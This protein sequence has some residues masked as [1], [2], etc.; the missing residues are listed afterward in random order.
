MEQRERELSE[1]A[2][3]NRAAWDAESDAYQAR[4]GEQLSD[5]RRGWGVWNIP[6]AEL[7]VLGEVAGQ[8]ILEFG[9]GGAQWSIWLAQQG[10]RPV[11]LD[12]SA[13]QLAHA[14]RFM[15]QAGVEFPL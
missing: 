1:A 7:N 13:Q 14:R 11:G 8:D 3:R 4:H 15:A 5:P 9:C 2:Q 6:E 10:A 12:N